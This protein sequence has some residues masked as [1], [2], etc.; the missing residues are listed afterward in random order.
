[1]V[2]MMSAP[3]GVGG[4]LATSTGP[5]LR[6]GKNGPS[7]VTNSGMRTIDAAPMPDVIEL[8]PDNHSPA[9]PPPSLDRPRAEAAARELLEALAVD[10]SVE[11]TAETPRRLVDVY[12]ELLSPAPFNPTTFPNDGGYD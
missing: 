12:A 7:A 10:V 2:L 5:V 8:R 1:M 9:G 4:D 6:R 11:S 3:F